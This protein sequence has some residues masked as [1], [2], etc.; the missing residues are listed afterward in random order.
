MR[1][2]SIIMPPKH[3]E[4]LISTT[5]LLKEIAHETKKLESMVTTLNERIAG[6]IRYPDPIAHYPNFIQS[7]DLIGIHEQHHFNLCQKYYRDGH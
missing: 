1:A 4:Q 2:P 6:H 5:T 3:V 7:I